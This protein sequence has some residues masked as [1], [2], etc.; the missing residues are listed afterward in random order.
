MFI[1]YDQEFNN[2]TNIHSTDFT[3][4]NILV[5]TANTIMKIY[6]KEQRLN[7]ILCYKH[8]IYVL[9]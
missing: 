6:Y 7:C 2:K 4:A 9:F 1:K 3:L 8:T 5:S